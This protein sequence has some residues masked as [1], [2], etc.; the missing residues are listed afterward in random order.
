VRVAALYDVH[1]NAAALDALLAEV[2]E[3]GADTLVFGG[4]VA[5][6]P[7]PAETLDRL[8]N[9]ALPARFVRGN[10]DRELVAAFDAGPVETQPPEESWE[11]VFP[12]AAGRMSPEQR[13]LL[14]GFEPSVTLTIDG[15]GRRS[16]VTPHRAATRRS[17]RASRRPPCSSRPSRASVRGLSSS[18]TP[19]SSS[20]STW[21]ESDS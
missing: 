20:S 21:P 1:G 15:L 14:A 10:C 2:A 9:L 8:A 6:G 16:S 12:W 17:S 19:T 13:D 18:G 4:D 11:A 7:F 3:S 5:L